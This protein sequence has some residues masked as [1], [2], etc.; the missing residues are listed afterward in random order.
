MRSVYIVKQHEPSCRGTHVDPEQR[1]HD[2][3]WHDTDSK[4]PNRPGVE[5]M[6]QR[7]GESNEE[8]S[9]RLEDRADV[10]DRE[11][12]CSRCYR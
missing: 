4:Y 10:L 12:G 9:Q 1:F 6:E 11:Y 3:Q 7:E 5:R 2:G 8:F